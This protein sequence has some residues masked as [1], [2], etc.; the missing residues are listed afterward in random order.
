MTDAGE[1]ARETAKRIV[2]EYI[3]DNIR[4][5]KGHKVFDLEDD[6]TIALTALETE[7]AELRR[8]RYAT[9]MALEQSELMVA[10]LKAEVERLREDLTQAQR[11]YEGPLAEENARLRAATSAEA[12]KVAEAARVYVNAHCVGNSSAKEQQ[13]SWRHL[14]ESV[15]AYDRAQAQR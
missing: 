7:N 14:K 11:E 10:T 5:P 8:D 9:V 3:G 15:A 1:R 12:V 2:N 4:D 13:G 6:I